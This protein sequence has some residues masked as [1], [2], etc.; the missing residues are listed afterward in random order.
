[1]SQP[2]VV[3]IAVVLVAFIAGY[4]IVSFVVKKWK[5]G[6]GD[7][8]LKNHGEQGGN[9]TTEDTLSQQSSDAY[10]QSHRDE[11]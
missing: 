6:P 3:I 10:K 8:S 11:G 2:N 1:M 4:S 5:E 9:S 7:P